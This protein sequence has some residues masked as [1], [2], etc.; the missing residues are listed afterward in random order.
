LRIVERCRRI[1]PFQTEGLPRRHAV[2]G[3]LVAAR[4][5]WSPTLQSPCHLLT[6]TIPFVA[7]VLD[8]A[9]D[10]SNRQPRFTF[11]WRGRL[12]QHHFRFVLET[13]AKLELVGL[14][15]GLKEVV[16]SYRQ[17]IRHSCRQVIRERV[18]L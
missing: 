6:A 17:I 8:P 7:A 2:D 11:P 15:Q 10:P 4:A 18:V 3:L 13:A 12:A 9:A 16:Q 14:V 1:G 5:R